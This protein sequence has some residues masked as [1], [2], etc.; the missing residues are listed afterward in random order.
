MPPMEPTERTVDVGGGIALHVREMGAGPLVLL[1]HGFPDCSYTWRNQL[2]ALAAAGFHAV[3]PDLRGYDGSSRPK[4]VAAYSTSAL[5]ADIAGLVTA[6]GEQRADVVAHDWGGGVAW[7][8]AMLHP[9]KLRRLAILNSPHPVTFRRR[10]RTLQQAKKSWYIFAFQLPVMPEL[11]LARNDFAS[12]RRVFATASIRPGAFTD[13]DVER[14][15]EALRPPGA[16]TAAIN[17]YRAVFRSAGRDPLRVRRVEHPV[18]VLWG[19]QDRFLGPE[20]AEPGSEWVPNARIR[21]VPEAGHWIQH[22]VPELVNDEL[23]RFLSG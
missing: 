5:S 14:H 12:L 10:L 13:A 9:G 18:L 4:G 3:A 16:L 8:F 7:T 20:L 11:G 23:V 17:Y 1:L 2:P 6:L 19:E 22:D 15:V 21:R